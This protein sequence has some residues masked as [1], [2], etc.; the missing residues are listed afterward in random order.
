[1]LTRTRVEQVVTRLGMADG[2]IFEALGTR[3]ELYGALLRYEDHE[4]V[5]VTLV[6][7][8]NQKVQVYLRRDTICGLFEEV[9]SHFWEGPSNVYLFPSAQPA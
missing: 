8:E 6:N 1:M 7:K 2:S 9:K 3:D 4:L 5:P